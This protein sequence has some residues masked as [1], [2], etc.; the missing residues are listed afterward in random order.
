MICISFELD[1]F[2]ISF[3]VFFVFHL[4]FNLI[5][6]LRYNIALLPKN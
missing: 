4:I 3:F 6:V 1:L 5:S 2:Y